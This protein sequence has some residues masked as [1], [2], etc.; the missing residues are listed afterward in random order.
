MLG[1]LRF[2][3]P[4]FVTQG[5]CT[6]APT[7]MCARA[8]RVINLGVNVERS[9]KVALSWVKGHTKMEGVVRGR[10]TWEDAMGNDCADALA[11]AGA[12]AHAPSSDVVSAAFDHRQVG[13]QVHGMMLSIAQ[14]RL[15]A[16]AVL[17]EADADRGSDLGDLGDIDHDCGGG[18]NN[19]CFCVVILAYVYVSSVCFR[20]RVFPPLAFYICCMC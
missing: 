20:M 19:D 16:E 18:D 5:L 9:S 14:A 12:T 6:F 8:F 11:V 4:A 13:L 3:L 17:C 2:W 1:R 15:A 10:T 7:S